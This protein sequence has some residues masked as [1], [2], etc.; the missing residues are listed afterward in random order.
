MI[1]FVAGSTACDTLV[2]A[3]RRARPTLQQVPASLLLFF[4][5]FF[6]FSFLNSLT[7]SLPPRPQMTPQHLLTQVGAAH[8]LTPRTLLV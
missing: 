3:P 4:S 1:D 2:F 8:F 6:T 5:S 7:W